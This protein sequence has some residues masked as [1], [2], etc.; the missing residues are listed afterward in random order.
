MGDGDYCYMH[1]PSR[2]AD[3][4]AARKKGGQ[5]RQTPHSD[6]YSGPRQVRSLSDVL[7]VLD[8]TLSEALQLENS[9]NRG[10]LLV[11]ICAEFTSAIKTGELEARLQALEMI[12]KAREK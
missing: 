10:R 9:L 4:A 1:E 6:P 8:Y 5:N 12:L 3:R 7:A 2:A 11:A